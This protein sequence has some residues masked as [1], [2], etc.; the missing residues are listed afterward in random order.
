[1]SFILLEQGEQIVI[2]ESCVIHLLLEL[3]TEESSSGIRILPAL[4]SVNSC[5]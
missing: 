4:S 1:M 5:F 2:M 3:L